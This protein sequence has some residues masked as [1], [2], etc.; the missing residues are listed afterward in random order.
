ASRPSARVPM[1][2]L[3]LKPADLAKQNVGRDVPF[4][5]QGM[6]SFTAASDAGNGFGYTYLRFR[7]MDQTRINVTVNNVALNDPESHGVFWVNTPDLGLNTNSLVVQRGVGTS[8]LGSGAFGASLSFEVGVPDDS[9]SQQLTVTYGSFQSARL[10]YAFHSGLMGAKKRWSTTGRVTAMGSQGFV[11]RSGSRLQS[12]LFGAQYRLQSYTWRLLHFAGSERTQ[13]AWY[14]IPEAKFRGDSAGVASYIG[15]NGVTGGDSLNLL[16]SGAATYNFY[17]YANEIDQYTQRHYHSLMTWSLSPTWSFTQT[18]AV[19]TGRGY[20]EQYRDFMSFASLG[21]PNM[22]GYFEQYRDFMSFASLGLPN[23]PMGQVVLTGTEGVRRRWLDNG[24]LMAATSI[25]YRGDNL[26]FVAGMQDQLYDGLHFGTLP[27]LRYNPMG[28]LDGSQ[29]VDS[30][31]V[32]TNSALDHRFYEGSSLKHDASYFARAEW[33]KGRWTAL[34][35]AQLRQIAYR[36]SGVDVDQNGYGFDVNYLF[37]NPK[38]GISYAVG[39]WTARGSAALAHREPI[40]SDFIDNAVAPRPERLTD[41]EL[42]IEKRGA[43]VW[44]EANVY[45]MDYTDQLV[46]TGALNDV[47][48]LIRTNVDRSHRR[49]IELAAVWTPTAPWQFGG[50]ATLS[51]NRIATFEEVMYDYADGSEVRTTFTN[52]PIALSPEAM[53]N[54]WAAWSRKGWGLRATFHAVGRQFLDNTG[55]LERSLDPYRTLD[56]TLNWKR[57]LVEWRL[58]PRG[59]APRRDQPLGPSLRAQRLHVGLPVARPAHRR[60]LCVPHGGHPGAAQLEFGPVGTA[61]RSALGLLRS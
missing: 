48:A 21:L 33:I 43:K 23:M 16:Q 58:D 38:G 29:T 59:V 46:P 13:Q 47:G 45:L 49:G 8:T 34:A 56:A 61:G 25:Q 17:R 57:G 41:V 52:T 14:G 20:F 37:F 60:K 54:A 11:D 9:A 2:Q 28:G 15:R 24:S 40:R 22:R 55:A 31:P 7:G 12:Y 51:R 19:V 35:D 10:S 42:G 30:L 36:S 1:P 5:L 4:L 3:R 44:A 6:P 32:P 27:W 26:R 18:L 39:G 53:G 50:N